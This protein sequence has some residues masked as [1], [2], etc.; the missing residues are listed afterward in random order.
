MTGSNG[1]GLTE[2]V[3][4]N[5]CKLTSDLHCEEVISGH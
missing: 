2:R 3:R 4:P 5:Q 1:P